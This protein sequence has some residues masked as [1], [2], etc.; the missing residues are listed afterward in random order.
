M[1]L[2]YFDFFRKQTIVGDSITEENFTLGV[3]L[4][5]DGKYKTA[6]P[7]NFQKPVRGIGGNLRGYFYFIVNGRGIEGGRK[8]LEDAVRDLNTQGQNGNKD[9]IVY[10]KSKIPGIEVYASHEDSIV[11]MAPRA[12]GETN[13]SLR[14]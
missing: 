1:N 5:N 14:F 9:P 13:I 3:Y 7:F 10:I 8:K 6:S 2:Q 11:G 4:D 12:K